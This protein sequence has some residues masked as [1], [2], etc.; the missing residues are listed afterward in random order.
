MIAAIVALIG[1]IA[2]GVTIGLATRSGQSAPPASASGPSSAGASTAR[3]LYAQALAAMRHSTGF[4]Y[5]ARSTGGG[6][7]QTIVGDAGSS[8]GRQIITVDG[9][10]GKEQF[11]LVLVAGTVYFQ[12]N[13]AA[14]ADQLGVPAAT[15]P[16]LSGRWVSVSDQDGPYSVVAPGI[17][18]GDQAAETSLVPASM[19]S[20]NAGGASVTRILGTVPPQQGS[21]GGNGHL[22]IAPGSHR[23]LSYMSTIPLT[24]QP[25]TS[26]VTFS[27]WAAVAETAPSGAVAWA[28]LGASPP[29]GGYGSGVGSLTPSPTSQT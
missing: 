10:A 29:P 23:P 15:A 24:G 4:H 14:L 5:V 16:G 9:N 8:A 3:A 27:H 19:S 25:A 26:T 22:D 13:V 11:T 18:T 7:A 1:G 20:V 17:T 2:I 21:P 28:T 6:A 12:G